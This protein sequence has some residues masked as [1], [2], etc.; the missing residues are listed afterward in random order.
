MLYKINKNK[1]AT[2]IIRCDGFKII[3]IFLAQTTGTEAS[4]ENT[5]YF[6]KRQRV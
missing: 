4:Y 6:Q 3:F 1:G 5:L 2:M